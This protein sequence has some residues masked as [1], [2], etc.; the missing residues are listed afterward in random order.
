MRQDFLL[1]ITKNCETLIKQTHSKAEQTLEFKTT[2]PRETL[3]FNPPVQIK[4]D[5]M[6]GLTSPEVYN[7]VFNRTKENNKFELYKFPDS[8]SA[9]VSAEKVR[10]EIERDLDISDFTASDLQYEILA[11]IFFWRI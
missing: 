11:P 6:I 5:W 7:S 8:K 1:S 3:H 9:G 2:K 10:N 4:E